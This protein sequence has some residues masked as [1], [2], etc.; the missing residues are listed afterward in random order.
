MKRVA[1]LFI[2]CVLLA[3]VFCMP[4][5]AESAATQVDLQCTVTS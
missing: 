4:V 5:S 1:V 3:G 2:L